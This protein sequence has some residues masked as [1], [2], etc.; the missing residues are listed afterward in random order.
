M[1]KAKS[2]CCVFVGADAL[3]RPL[4]SAQF[5]GGAQTVGAGLR[6]TPAK[7]D[8]TF[9]KAK[10]EFFILLVKWGI[11]ML[12]KLRSGGRGNLPLRVSADIIQIS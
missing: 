10:I 2:I 11:F 7:S 8:G 3:I 4:K 12:P 1:T 5:D 9:Y 6:V